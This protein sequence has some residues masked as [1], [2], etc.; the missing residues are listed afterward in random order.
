MPEPQP[1][2]KNEELLAE[3][4]IGGMYIF[5]SRFASMWLLSFYYSVASL[6]SCTRLLKRQPARVK[7]YC[8][9]LVDLVND[10]V[11]ME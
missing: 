10:K 6:L 3:R 5:Y 9:E 8:V 2:N 1:G 11:G 7:G 4:K